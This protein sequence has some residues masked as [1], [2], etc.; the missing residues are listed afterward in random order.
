MASPRSNWNSRQ[1]RNSL[2]RSPR[3]REFSKVSYRQTNHFDV[4]NSEL[5][6]SVHVPVLSDRIAISGKTTILDDPDGCLPRGHRS[7]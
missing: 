3:S 7:N 6:W 5:R 1:P 4:A 2:P